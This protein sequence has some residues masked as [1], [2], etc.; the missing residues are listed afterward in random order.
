MDTKKIS[1]FSK[2]QKM[3]EKEREELF[4]QYNQTILMTT[5]RLILE[6]MEDK[7]KEAFEKIAETN[8]SGEII[9][10]GYN[11][12]PDFEYKYKALMNAITD[13]FLNQIDE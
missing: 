13:I 2:F 5:Y 3:S 6:E 9:L 11:H 4:E 8:D 7:D 1:L 12:I 10:F